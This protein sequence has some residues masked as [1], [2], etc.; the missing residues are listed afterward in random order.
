MLAR[1]VRGGD[2]PPFLSPSRGRTKTGRVRLAG[3]V[4]FLPWRRGG[5][6][7]CLGCYGRCSRLPWSRGVGCPPLHRFRISFC[8]R[9][10]RVSTVS[11][12]SVPDPVPRKRPR[13][14]S[15]PLTCVAGG[16]G[17]VGLVVDTPVWGP[18]RPCPSDGWT[19]V[20]V[21][22][23]CESWDRR[24]VGTAKVGSG[25][26]T[27]LTRRLHRPG[28]RGRPGGELTDPHEVRAGKE[29]YSALPLA[30]SPADHSRG[31][32]ATAPSSTVLA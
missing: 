28:R 29:I 1:R 21:P 12:R 13:K 3:V 25:T 24:S 5:P 20:G 8:G 14:P 4:L 10:L 2:K 9:V 30:P 27:S 26:S 15:L 32:D 17:H 23:G 7:V 19:S 31:G 6:V 16:D 18:T 11:T 22:N